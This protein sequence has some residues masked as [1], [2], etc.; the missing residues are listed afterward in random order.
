M[1]VLSNKK[2]NISIRKT[3]SVDITASYIYFLRYSRNE[4]HNM[5]S[6]LFSQNENDS[7][8]QKRPII[9]GFPIFHDDN[10]LT[11]FPRIKMI[12]THTNQ[13]TFYKWIKISNLEIDI[14]DLKNDDVKWSRI[15]YFEI[16]HAPSELLLLLPSA[17]KNLPRQAELAQEVS[18]YL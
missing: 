17:K 18:R 6:Y 2:R 9:Y 10:F 13:N 5:I 12:P 15:F 14:F 11:Y 1:Y 8:S 7:N 16:Q 4:H 3:S